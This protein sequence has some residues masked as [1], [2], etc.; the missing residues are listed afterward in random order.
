MASVVSERRGKRVRYRVQFRDADG[1]RRSIRL[2]GLNRKAAEAV[3]SK[4][5]ALNACKISGQS[6]PTDLAQW[7]V[8]LGDELHGKLGTAGLVEPRR[9]ST[10]GAFIDSYI[11]SR[12][13]VEGRTHINWKS[14]RRK[15]TDFFGEHRGLRDITEADADDWRRPS[16]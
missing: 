4:V 16:A 15:L 2:S 14:T 5:E 1:K 9:S 10:L 11:A 7:V 6:M 3:A 8:N 12:S 13:D